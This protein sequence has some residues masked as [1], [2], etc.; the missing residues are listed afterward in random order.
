MQS[1]SPAAKAFFHLLSIFGQRRRRI[2]VNPDPVFKPRYGANR[3]SISPKL[4]DRTRAV[5]RIERSR[6]RFGWG[7]SY[8]KRRLS[9]GA[10]TIGLASEAAL[11][12]A[13]L[14][15]LTAPNVNPLTNCFCVNQPITM[16]GPTA[17]REAAESCAKN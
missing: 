6:S 17:N 13:H 2:F 1:E 3:D 16:I 12:N 15:Y 11:H 14:H 5:S 7:I 10:A 8:L 4:S 9:I